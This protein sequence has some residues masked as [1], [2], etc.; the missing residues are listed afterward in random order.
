M[1]FDIERMLIYVS[2]L[3]FSASF[4]EVAHGFTAFLFGD[5][6]AKISGRLTLNPLAHIDLQ[7]SLIMPVIIFAASGGSMI[8]GYAKPVPVNPYALKN[9]K[10][11]MMVIAAAGPISNLILAVF[12]G[13]IM[14]MGLGEI[15]I[16]K[17]ICVFGMFLNVLLALFNLIPMPPLD[18]SRIVTGLL[19]ND[20]AKAYNS[21]E[22]FGIFILMGLI[23]TGMLDTSILIE[24]CRKF[25]SFFV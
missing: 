18:G 8:Y 9:P 25:V 23:L 10:K 22:P 6:T 20:L 15:F 13:L 2:L 24:I 11:A 12:F 19:P 14:K 1:S 5:N 3:I 16:I 4:H 17:K 7:G 21:I